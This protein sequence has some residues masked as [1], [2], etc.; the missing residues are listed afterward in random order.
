MKYNKLT[1]EELASERGKINVEIGKRKM[2]KLSPKQMSERMSCVRRGG[3]YDIKTGKCK[4]KLGV[5]F[6][7]NV[8]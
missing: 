4:E 7:S 8:V 6:S 1:I 3:S 2:G 5:D